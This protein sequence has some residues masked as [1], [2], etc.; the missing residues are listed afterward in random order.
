MKM[1]KRPP[2]YVIKITPGTWFGKILAL[3]C[4]L[5]LLILAMLFFSFFA[6][7]M[8]AIVPILM[9]RAIFLGNA[10]RPRRHRD[11]ID[12]EYSVVP[13][14]RPAHEAS[15]QLPDGREQ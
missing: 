3:A 5:A 13:N 2:R 8:L 1:E 11:V 12:G 9:A 10:S 15:E 4:A 7:L 6:M 14:E